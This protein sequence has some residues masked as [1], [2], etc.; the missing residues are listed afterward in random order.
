M[1]KFSKKRLCVDE[2]ASS[3]LL[4]RL[5][6]GEFFFGR[7]LERLV[8]FR[9]EHRDG[10]SFFQGVALEFESAFNH[11]AGR[12][13]HV[14]QDTAL[15][16]R[17]RPTACGSADAAQ[18]RQRP[19]PQPR[20]AARWHPATTKATLGRVIFSLLLGGKLALQLKPTSPG[21]TSS[22]LRKARVACL[23]NSCC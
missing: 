15:A 20:Y 21:S 5:L 8:E 22:I 19:D 2:L 6:K 16:R 1:A 12:D 14:Q 3:R 10:G 7:E 18:R 4:Q 13:S 23:A 11:F 9:N 17:G